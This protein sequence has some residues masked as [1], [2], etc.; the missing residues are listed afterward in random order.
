MILNSLSQAQHHHLTD[1]SRADHPPAR[2]PARPEIV[3]RNFSPLETS[4]ALFSGVSGYLVLFVYRLGA[5][6]SGLQEPSYS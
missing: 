4:R 5:A 3:R 6:E 2:Q 1:W